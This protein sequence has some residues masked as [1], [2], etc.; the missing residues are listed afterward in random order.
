MQVKVKKLNDIAVIPTYAHP[1][2]DAGMDLTAVSCTY[3]AKTDCWIYGTGLAFEVPEGHMMLIFPRSSNR[4]TNA[5]LTNSVGVIDAGYRGEVMVSFKNRTSSAL[6]N[7]INVMYNKI[8]ETKWDH[9][10]HIKDAP[11]N[12]GDRVAQAIIV[13]YPTIEYLE[14][15]ELSESKRGANGHGSSGK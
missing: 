7:F 13:P 15:D 3:D 4:K 9:F 5:Y 1:G 10:E 12:V 2:E 11:Y 6:L 14:V 8:F